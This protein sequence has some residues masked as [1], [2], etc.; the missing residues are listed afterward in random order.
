MRSIKRGHIHHKQPGFR[1]E[2]QFIE[3]LFKAA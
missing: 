2:I 1:G 3:G